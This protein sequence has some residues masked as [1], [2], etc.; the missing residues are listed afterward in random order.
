[1]DI[2]CKPLRVFSE[3]TISDLLPLSRRRHV[4]RQ[5]VSKVEPTDETR[6]ARA[7]ACYHTRPTIMIAWLTRKER[8]YDDSQTPTKIST[9]GEALS[10]RARPTCA[11]LAVRRAR[12]RTA[13]RTGRAPRQ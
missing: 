12:S 7:T 4:R 9:S 2:E 6:R 10:C 1:M 11:A 13:G 3:T 8:G 5:A